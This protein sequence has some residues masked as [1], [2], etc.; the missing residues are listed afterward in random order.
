ML[1]IAAACAQVPPAPPRPPPG[2][3]E[4]AAVRQVLGD[5]ANRLG[6]PVAALQP[7]RVEPVTWRD[8]ALGCPEPGL[9]YPQV[10]VPGYRITVDSGGKSLEYHASQRGQ[11]LY[12]PPGRAMPPLDGAAGR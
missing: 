11:F 7:A 5:A 9:M 8:G 6:L 2:P 3:G 1:A 10:L 4:E 12:C